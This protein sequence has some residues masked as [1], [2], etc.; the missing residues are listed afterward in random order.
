MTEK[1]IRRI[2]ARARRRV[3]RKRLVKALVGVVQA[4]ITAWWRTKVTRRCC[5]TCEHWAPWK[6]SEGLVGRCTA[7]CEANPSTGRPQA[8]WTSYM[9]HCKNWHKIQHQEVPPCNTTAK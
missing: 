4:K 9:T 3:E 6:A 5:R 1:D 2:A 7:K 8:P